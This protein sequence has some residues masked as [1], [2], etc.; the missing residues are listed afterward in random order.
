[1]SSSRSV[2]ESNPD[3]W[4]RLEDAIAILQAELANVG[5]HG[6]RRCGD[7]G[8]I[9]TA[10]DEV[11]AAEEEAAVTG[12]GIAGGIAG[13]ALA[14]LSCGPGAPVCVGIGAFVGAALAASGVSLMF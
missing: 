13:G 14:G 9:A 11:A 4:A 2:Q 1:M 3:D 5:V 6:G 10:E 8:T 12:A 7:A